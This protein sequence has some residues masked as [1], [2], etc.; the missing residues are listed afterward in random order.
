MENY[1]KAINDAVKNNNLGLIK[2]FKFVK[3]GY[4]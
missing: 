4:N 3:Y 1:E 2:R